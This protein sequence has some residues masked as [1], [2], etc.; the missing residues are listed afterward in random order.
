MFLKF[1]I[2]TGISATLVIYFQKPLFIE[3]NKYISIE[4]VQTVVDYVRN[5]FIWIGT[6]GGHLGHTIT[7]KKPSKLKHSKLFSVNDLSK[8]NGIE[9]S[10][11]LYLSILGKVYDVKKG[12]RHYGPGGS[13]HSFAG[14]DASR[15]FITGDFNETG[16]S[17]D[18]LDLT[19]Q[20]LKSIIHWTEFYAR[21]YKY[22]G[23]LIGRYYDAYGKPTSYHNEVMNKIK[24]AK[25]K[26]VDEENEKLSYPPCNSEWSQD[27]G[28]RVWCS[29]LSGGIQRDWVGVPRMLYEPGSESHRCAC[30]KDPTNTPVKGRFQEYKDCHP[31]AASCKVHS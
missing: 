29:S 18:V 23:K 4:D 14:K 6:L 2:L 9:G 22:R 5:T 8:Y 24:T 31:K 12:K 10:K 11:G 21:D 19:P 15:A 7:F 1:F 27:L 16:L 17:D 25:N 20:E 28:T 30:I 13:Y 3:I 26:M